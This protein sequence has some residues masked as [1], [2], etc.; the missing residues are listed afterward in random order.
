[1]TYEIEQL[2]SR[3]RGARITSGILETLYDIGHLLNKLILIFDTFIGGILM[4]KN[5]KIIFQGTI[6]SVQPRI[7]LTRSF[8]QSSHTYLGFLLRIEGEIVGEEREFT[9]G[10]GK[11]TQEKHKFKYHDIIKGKCLSVKNPDLEPVEY[12][13]VSGLETINTSSEQEEPPPWIDNPPT[14]E[15]YRERGHRRLSKR[16]YN[17]KCIPCI[18]GC[19]MAVEMIIDQWNPRNKQFR[20]ETFCY[21]PKSCEFYKSGPNRKVP[22]RKGMVWEEP[23]WVDEENTAHRGLNE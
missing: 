3:L 16:T 21:G 2:G 12:Y 6:I 14:L 8:D 11:A 4:T 20:T 23:D 15:E 5:K 9:V 18:W 7:R 10:I 19:C 13:K 17:S 22:G 1:M